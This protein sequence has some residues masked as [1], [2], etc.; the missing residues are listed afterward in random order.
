MKVTDRDVQLKLANLRSMQVN[1]VEGKHF[2][3]SMTRF[4]A[5]TC[6]LF[7]MESAYDEDEGEIASFLETL[8]ELSVFI[9]DKVKKMDGDG[10][11]RLRAENQ[12]IRS[13]ECL[14]PQ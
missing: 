4:E 10:S 14:H 7:F 11:A 13:K 9:E 6:L 1:K 12:C 8:D 3:T 2:L 5:I